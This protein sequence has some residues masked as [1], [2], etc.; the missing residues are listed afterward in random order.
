VIEQLFRGLLRTD[1][2][3]TVVPELAQNMTVSADGL[4]YLFMVREDAR[5][6]DGEPVTAGDFVLAWRRL[7]EEGHPTAFLLDDIAAAEALDDWTLE[8]RLHE[9]RNYFPYVLASHWA[10]PWPSHRVEELGAAWR[11]PASLVGNGPFALQSAGQD[12]A[13]L[14]ANPHWHGGGGDVGTVRMHYREHGKPSIADWTARHYDV[15]IAAD[16]ASA[17]PQGM[18]EHTPQLSTTFLAVN[19]ETEPM[20]DAR[21]RLAIAHAI[22]RRTNLP[23]STGAD[24]PAGR[25]GLVPPAMP[26]HD[27]NAAPPYDPDRA[28]EL[29]AE[30]GYPGGHGLPELIITSHPWRPGPAIAEMLDAVGVRARVVEPQTRWGR[31]SGCHLWL[32]S[33][34]AD[35]PDPDGL[36]LG[37]LRMKE[38]CADEE[39]Q[40]MLAAARSSRSR[41]ER[42]RLYRELERV[43][44]GERAAVVPLSYE[45]QLVLRRPHVRHL[46]VNAMRVAHLEQVVVGAG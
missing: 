21:L 44:V 24:R 40:A 38:L 5:W 29:L 36:F 31:D 3:L 9:P 37:L 27:A 43:W 22:D 45:R 35:Y 39:V 28:R 18:A 1:H 13:V 11:D 8:L 46:A 12:G 26:G 10:Y 6:S 34:H 42:L 4:T 33:W 17:A 2:N 23:G 15:A 7:R 14:V 20:G 19:S 16:L 41:D 25:G 32:S 30:A